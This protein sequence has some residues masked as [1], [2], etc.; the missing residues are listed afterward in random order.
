MMRQ[1]ASTGVQNLFATALQHHQAGRLQ[2][3]EQLYRKVLRTAPHHADTLH[4]LGILSHQ[5]GRNDMA[6]DLIGEA[7][8]QNGRVAAFHNNLGMVLFEQGKLKGATA[9]YRRAVAIKSDYVEAHYNLAVALQ[10]EGALEEAMASYAVVLNHNPG[11]PEAHCN[12]GII[13]LALGELEPAVESLERALLHRPDHAAAHNNLGNVRKEQGKLQEALVSYQRALALQPDYP[14][15]HSNLGI[16]LM[17]QGKLSDAAASFRHALH[18]K[19]DHVAALSN[20][21]VVLRELGQTQ[22]AGASYQRALA[23][24]PEYAEARLG[25][26]MTAIPIFA[27]S[28]AESSGTPDR[29]MRSLE[30]LTA[31]H[32]AHPEKLGRVVGGHQPFYLAYRPSD[33]AEPLCRY[34]DLLCT[35][36]SAYWRQNSVKDRSSRPARDRIR[37]VVVSGQVRQHPAWEVVLKGV[38]AH[39]DRRKF[40]V[41]LYHTSSICDSETAWAKAHVDRFVQG[42]K[43][44]KAWLDEVT[45]DHPDVMFYPEVGMDAATCALAALRLAPLQIAGWGHPVTTGLPTLDLFLSGELL[46]GPAADRHYRETLIRLPGTG[47]CTQLMSPESTRW[48][49]PNRKAGVVRFVMCQQPIKFDPADDVLLT[50]IAKAVGPSEFWLAS[51]AKLDWTAQKLRDRLAA[52]F[53]A[54]GL[55]P[56][57]HLRT[58]PWL[59]RDQFLGFLDE[60]DVYLDCPSFSGYTTA[61]Q[62]IH[63]GVP[64]VTVEG[65]F[66]RQRLAAGLL[67]Q[68]GITDQIASSREAYVDIA[69][70]MAEEC[71][72]QSK[73]RVIRR[74]AIRSAAHRADGNRSAVSA[75]E[76]VLIESWQATQ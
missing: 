22:A 38:I 40:E 60:M 55:E 46:E 58:I 57:S 10:A 27:E 56:E 36:A 9:S 67:R 29:F 15:V 44:I 25:L 1:K 42:P 21:G 65:E 61:W 31:W 59:P 48:E 76:Q 66:L 23:L 49:G 16:V 41:C 5:C 39:L 37:L 34:G 7:I 74:Q 19:P 35:S 6:V 50:R 13:L 52:C 11:H 4:F 14:E 28:E 71:R 69:V 30:E 70:R 62:A 26:A 47:V 43:P 3:A 18:Y 54:E 12:R 8:A 53:R 32:D 51:P 63:R 20:L 68:I 33:I 2:E 24:N 64:I 72:A 45:H 73:E 17:E 75:M